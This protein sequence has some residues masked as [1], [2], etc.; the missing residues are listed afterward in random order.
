MVSR[1]WKLD[2]H[3]RLN[4]GEKAQRL[5]CVSWRDLA[6]GPSGCQHTAQ[7]E[8]PKYPSPNAQILPMLYDP[9]WFQSTLSWAGVAL[10]AVPSLAE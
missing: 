2:L 10:P 1:V 5:G 7:A 4:T 8:L 3:Q 6:Q 9:F